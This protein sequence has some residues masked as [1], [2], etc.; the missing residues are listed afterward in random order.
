MPGAGYEGLYRMF[1]LNVTRMLLEVVI[2]IPIS[3]EE[4]VE[5]IRTQAS[6]I[7]KPVFPSLYRHTIDNGQVATK[8]QL[9]NNSRYKANNVRLQS[10]SPRQLL[11]MEISILY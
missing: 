2:I 11:P 9:N 5:W 1:H 4:A 10:E 6:L 3:Q 7:L 8:I